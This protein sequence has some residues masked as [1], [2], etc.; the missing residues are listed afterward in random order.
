MIKGKSFGYWCGYTIGNAILAA[1]TAI[2]VGVLAKG[3]WVA[4]AWMWSS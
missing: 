4:L 2:V 1:L 3:V